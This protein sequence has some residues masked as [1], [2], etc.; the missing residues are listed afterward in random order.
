[1]LLSK[2]RKASV[3]LRI[4]IIAH[5]KTRAD[6]DGIRHVRAV[7]GDAFHIFLRESCTLE[8]SVTIS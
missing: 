8:I 1:M 3:N 4:G 6:M 2:H 5:I 7:F